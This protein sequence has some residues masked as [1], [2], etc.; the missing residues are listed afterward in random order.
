VG[1]GTLLGTN[2][3]RVF[4]DRAQQRKGCGRSIMDEQGKRAMEDGVRESN[5]SSS[6]VSKR[7]HD[8]LGYHTQ[9]S[10]FVDVGN[11]QRRDPSVMVKDLS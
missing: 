5:L 2:M 3:R 7:F 10:T 6:V 1:T 11:G 8:S 9:T 4:V